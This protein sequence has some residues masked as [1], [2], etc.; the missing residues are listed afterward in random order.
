[1][2]VTYFTNDKNFKNDMV[3]NIIHIDLESPT[4]LPRSHIWQYK[5][6]YI[7]KLPSQTKRIM[8][9]DNDTEAI[10]DIT[11]AFNLLDD[12]DLVLTSINSLQDP[13]CAG[14]FLFRR[15]KKMKNFLKIWLEEQIKDKDKGTM[16]TDQ[17]VLRKLVTNKQLIKD[18]N[19]KIKILHNDKFHFRC[20]DLD[21]FN[22]NI[23]RFNTKDIKLIHAHS[24][25]RNIIKQGIMNYRRLHP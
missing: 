20:K 24:K 19:L 12:F 6:S 1:M 23:D 3:D 11:P 13:I 17:A 14:F 8:F 5:I 21:F 4:N 16:Y 25:K 10:G 9:L 2:Y 15:N 18:L 22:Q 7:D